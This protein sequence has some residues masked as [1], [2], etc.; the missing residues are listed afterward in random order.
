M[1]GR[2]GGEGGEAGVRRRCNRAVGGL[3]RVEGRV[4]GSIVKQP[5]CR[6]YSKSPAFNDVINSMT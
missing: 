3:Q 4:F 1:E 2:V 6:N 5:S